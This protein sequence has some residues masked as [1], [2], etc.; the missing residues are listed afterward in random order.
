MA[1][2]ECKTVVGPTPLITVIIPTYRRPK[3][4]GRAIRSVLNQTFPD[5]Q[6]CVY[7]NASGDE[8]TQ[9]VVEFAERDSRVRYHC[10]A[11]NIGA[12]PA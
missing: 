11:A 1:P 2:E 10:H 5:L 3:M 7:D 9:V 6:V 4:L 8:T 12:I